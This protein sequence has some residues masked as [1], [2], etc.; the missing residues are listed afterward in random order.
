MRRLFFVFCIFIFSAFSVS[1]LG[2][3][4]RNPEEVIEAV[5]RARMQQNVTKLEL[6]AMHDHE[7]SITRSG[8]QWLDKFIMSYTVAEI[9]IK[10]FSH[11]YA[12]V[13]LKMKSVEFGLV[14]TAEYWKLEKKD[15]IWTIVNIFFEQTESIKAYLSPNMS[16]EAMIEK[17]IELDLTG[18]TV[19]VV[20]E[21]EDIEGTHMMRAAHFFDQ[22]YKYKGNFRRAVE[23]VNI[24]IAESRRIPLDLAWGYLLKGLMY[25]QYGK[26]NNS[27]W[28][29][30]E[31]YRQISL[32]IQTDP[33]PYYALM[34]S[35]GSGGG[36]SYSTQKKTETR[37]EQRSYGVEKMF[38]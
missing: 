30:E 33:R 3:L 28:Y 32:S 18:Y 14:N 23:Q 13:E 9:K 17:L 22:R 1:M 34:N 15:G 16:L 29:Q 24:H 19:E 21:Y 10:S 35:D 4:N 2:A 8:K 38:K 11:A 26:E 7:R 36:L 5:Y 31:G 20:E 25:Y 27:T 12:R 37:T 6:L